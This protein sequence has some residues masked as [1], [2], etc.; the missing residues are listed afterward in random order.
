ML[1]VL[2]LPRLADSCACPSIVGSQSVD[3]V[4]PLSHIA[5]QM[6]CLCCKYDRKTS[7]TR[8]GL[9]CHSTSINTRQHCVLACHV[10]EQPAHSCSLHAEPRNVYNVL[11]NTS[12]VELVGISQFYVIWMVLEATSDV[13]VVITLRRTTPQLPAHQTSGL[14][15]S[16]AHCRMLDTSH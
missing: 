1:V 5:K 6:C 2:S 7:S 9:S 12:T 16:M 11:V 13:C 3:R 14:P 15:H 8:D 4:S 10:P